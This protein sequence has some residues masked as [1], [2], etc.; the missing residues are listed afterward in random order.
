MNVELSRFYHRSFRYNR[1]RPLEVG[2]AA[3]DLRIFER[4]GALSIMAG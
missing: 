2:T 4:A 3:C 1:S